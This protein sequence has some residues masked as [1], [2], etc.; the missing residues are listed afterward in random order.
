MV[1]VGGC[2]TARREQQA[3]RGSR[4]QRTQQSAFVGGLTR[5]RKE[6]HTWGA[7]KECGPHPWIKRRSPVAAANQESRQ[8]TLPP[9]LPRSALPSG[10]HRA[11]QG[12]RVLGERLHPPTLSS[13]GCGGTGSGRCWGQP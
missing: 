12:A 6:R 10:L 8:H 4:P 5:P 1:P 7:R 3:D 2:I 13:Q 11:P 9:A